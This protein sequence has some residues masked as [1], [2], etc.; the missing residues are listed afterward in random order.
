MQWGA[1]ETIANEDGYAAAD[2]VKN[3]QPD[4]DED[5]KKRRK[6][7]NQRVRL[8]LARAP[9]DRCCRRRG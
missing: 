7:D 9:A 8:M 5:S 1:D 6:A 4:G 3:W 2:Y